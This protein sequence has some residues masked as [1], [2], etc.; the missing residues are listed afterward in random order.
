MII[1]CDRN[2]LVQAFTEPTFPL[3]QYDLIIFCLANPSNKGL[4]GIILEDIIIDQQYYLSVKA[5][6]VLLYIKEIM[7]D[8]QWNIMFQYNNIWHAI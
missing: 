5:S 6:Q 4:D 3:K 2:I 7:Q 8:L 1:W